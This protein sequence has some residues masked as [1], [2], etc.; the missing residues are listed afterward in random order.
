VP[1]ER[2][3]RA[4]DRIG[5]DGE[6]APGRHVAVALAAQPVRLDQRGSTRANES[7]EDDY[8]VDVL[9]ELQLDDD[10][11]GVSGPLVLSVQS[12]PSSWV[13]LPESPPWWGPDTLTGS[14]VGTDATVTDAIL[15]VEFADESWSGGTSL[16]GES[17]SGQSAWVL[18]RFE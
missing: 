17:D 4:G 6:P 13:D 15:D 7:C 9:V 8:L 1:L 5:V 12:G 3:D 14:L 11:F 2:I 18:L 16:R 10:A